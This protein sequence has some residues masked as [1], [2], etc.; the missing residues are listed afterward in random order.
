MDDRG[1]I[2]IWD[3]EFAPT[4]MHLAATLR[5]L[6]I[7]ES[8]YLESPRRGRFFIFV[9]IPGMDHTRSFSS[10][11]EVSLQQDIRTFIK[12]LQDLGRPIPLVNTGCAPAIS[13]SIDVM[14]GALALPA[15]VGQAR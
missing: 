7:P 8:R 5:S 14:L 13:D 9:A 4:R 6:K 11:D 1:I 2:T 3:H 10:D 12:Q 15:K